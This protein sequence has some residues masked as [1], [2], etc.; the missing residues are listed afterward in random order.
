M[1]EHIQSFKLPM[2][3]FSCWVYS[4]HFLQ[5][6]AVDDIHLHLYIIEVAQDTD[7]FCHVGGT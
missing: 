6:E 1:S 3:L 2:R 4:A 7:S 5:V